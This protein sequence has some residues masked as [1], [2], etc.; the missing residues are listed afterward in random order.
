MTD[1]GSDN[2]SLPG[3]QLDASKMPGHWLLARMGKRVLRPGGLKM[4]YTLLDALKI[5]WTDNVVEFAPGLAATARQIIDMKPASYIGIER[6]KEAVEFTTQQ[7]TGVPIAKVIKGSASESTLA[8]GEASIVI[9]EAMLSMQTQ[10]QKQQIANEAFR[11][12]KP[13]GQY[14]IHE[15]SITPE[16]MPFEMKEEIKNALSNAINIGARPLTQPEWCKL[17]E[18]AGFEITAIEYAP[19]HL[20]KPMRMIQDEG[21]L[22]M[23]RIVKNLMFDKTAKQRV[24]HMRRVFKRYEEY[25]SAIMVI[26]RKP[27]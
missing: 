23:L 19:M 6:D 9:G 5:D 1:R 26:A 20:L 25:L 8:D 24:M 16:R 22:G 4:T 3:A 18:D 10:Q 14:G 12:L 2:K 7:L 15:L 13:G 21:F 27:E 17:L 11:I